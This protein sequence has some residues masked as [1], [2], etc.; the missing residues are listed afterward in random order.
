MLFQHHSIQMVSVFSCNCSGVF[1]YVAFFRETKGLKFFSH[2]ILHYL[3]SNFL[4]SLIYQNRFI[5]F[6]I[7]TASLL[8]K[9]KNKGFE[10]KSFTISIVLKDE[11]IYRLY[12]FSL[13]F[14]R[15]LFFSLQRFI[16]LF[17]GFTHI[18]DSIIKNMS[19]TIFHNV[20]LSNVGI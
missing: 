6:C 12:V 14:L 20:Q 9:A 7:Y 8:L 4:V 2:M 17:H 1:F 15:T 13:K 19:L 10:E 11:K 5:R 3:F 18:P 16:K